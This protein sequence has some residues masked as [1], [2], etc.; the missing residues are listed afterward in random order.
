MELSK[1]LE[2][3]ETEFFTLNEDYNYKEFSPEHALHVLVESKV[4]DVVDQV[5][6]DE[7]DGEYQH[8]IFRVC[9]E[10][11]GSVYLKYEGHYNSWSGTNEWYEPKLVLPRKVEVIQYFDI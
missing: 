9:S 10:E 11:F 4:I 6:G 1:A 7:G 3:I 8:I 2:I 5:G